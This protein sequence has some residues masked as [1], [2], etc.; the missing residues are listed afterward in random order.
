MSINYDL[1]KQHQAE[2]KANAKK[3]ATDLKA[4]DFI[5]VYMCHFKNDGWNAFETIQSSL[6][7]YGNE[8]I[9]QCL[10]KI[11][12][13]VSGVSVDDFAK[14]VYQ[15]G[16]GGS[17]S[18]CIDDDFNRFNPKDEEI[19]TF[20]QLVTLII[21]EDGRHAFVD[22]Q[23]YDYPRYVGIPLN[24]EELFREEIS[25]V[26]KIRR[27]R[28]ALELKARREKYAQKK[29]E[30][31]ETAY[32]ILGKDYKPIRNEADAVRRIFRS[33]FPE[34]KARIRMARKGYSDV[35]V[36]LPKEARYSVRNSYM[37]LYHRLQYRDLSIRGVE[38]IHTAVNPLPSPYQICWENE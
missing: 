16:D 9:G 8:M 7:S 26:R 27:E 21:L 18:D 33:L 23:G 22:A 1:F 30:A 5:Y 24:G 25:Q 14:S 34:I 28:E 17:Q 2:G 37:D 31:F 15:F 4:G 38:V 6:D 35:I 19:S 10:A 20:Y 36:I 3:A 12:M 32:S 11:E 29:A 13:I